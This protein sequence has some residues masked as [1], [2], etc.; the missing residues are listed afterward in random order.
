MQ[1]KIIRGSQKAWKSIKFTSCSTPYLE[2]YKFM[3]YTV[4][5][6]LAQW[7][8][9]ETGASRSVAIDYSPIYQPNFFYY[10]GKIYV[11]FKI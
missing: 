6:Y 4:P 5:L 8:S 2:W 7:V 11:Y 10:F 1:K 9:V 3:S